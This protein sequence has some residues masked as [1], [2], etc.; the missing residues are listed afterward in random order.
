VS[1]GLSAAEGMDRIYCYQR[2]IYDVTRRHYL[3]GRDTL[4]DHLAPPDGGSIL[5]IGCG[6]AR[7]LIRAAEHHPGTALFGVDVSAAMLGTAQNRVA[8][9]GFAGRVRL[10]HADATSFDS[11][12]VFGR[13][14]FDRVFISYALSMIPSWQSV[15]DR[16][17][18][19]LAPRGSMH[20][21]D[22]GGCEGLPRPM[23]SALHA[24]LAR[25]CVTPREDL[26]AV[27][28]ALAVRRE[29]DVFF[30]S[31]YRGYAAFAVLTQR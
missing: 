27:L 13:A 23:R 8:A 17:A 7:N 4:I 15:L 28:A 3:L 6:T 1:A 30:A 11:Q 31:L 14:H 20:I 29:L 18:A 9:S 10:A 5:E 16:A 12:A 22:F 2:F 26:A 25:F 21:V 19:L 24:W